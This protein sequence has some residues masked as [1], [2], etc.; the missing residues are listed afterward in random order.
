M[1]R[2]PPLHPLVLLAL[3]LGPVVPVS[4]DGVVEADLDAVAFVRGGSGSSG[5][6]TTATLLLRA[7]PRLTGMGP[8]SVH[9]RSPTAPPGWDKQTAIV[10]PG[11]K[12]APAVTRVDISLAGWADGDHVLTLSAFH[13]PHVVNSSMVRWL[14]VATAPGLVPPTAALS[15]DPPLFIPMVDDHWLASRSD[16]L[17][18]RTEQP[19]LLPITN[20]SFGAELGYVPYE[21]LLNL[22]ATPDG[23]GVAARF[24]LNNDGNRSAAERVVSCHSSPNGAEWSCEYEVPAASAPTLKDLPPANPFDACKSCRMYKFVPMIS[25]NLPLFLGL[26]V[27]NRILGAGTTT[28]QTGLST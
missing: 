26:L 2:R 11:G 13:P 1:S 15:I 24:T 18:R 27:T 6:G 28:T 22:T 9:V 20:A 4:I 14:R 5:G 16:G 7:L 12:S 10:T 8:L 17:C 23:Q 19:P 25:F 21:T 3:A